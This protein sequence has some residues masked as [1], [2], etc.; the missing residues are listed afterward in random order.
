MNISL[1]LG[2]IFFIKVIIM[3][4]SKLFIAGILCFST[5]GLVSCGEKMKIVH[6]QS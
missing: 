3:R 5:L 2:I 6:T 4:T 1:A